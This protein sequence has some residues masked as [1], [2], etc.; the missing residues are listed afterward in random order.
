MRTIYVFLILSLSIFSIVSSSTPH[1]SITPLPKLLTTLYKTPHD[2]SVTLSRVTETGLESE[3]VL[4]ELLKEHGENV[5][6]KGKT[7]SL[8]KRISDEFKDRLVQVSLNGREEGR[9]LGNDN[10]DTDHDTYTFIT[11]NNPPYSSQILLVTAAVSALFS[12]LELRSHKLLHPTVPISPLSVFVEP[13]VIL[14]IL[15]M[16]AAVGV[17][18]GMSAESS[19]SSLSKLNPSTATLVR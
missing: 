11:L 16:N 1:A 6:P 10:N 15:F 2:N 18:M 8:I 7:R 14:L 3:N 9:G 12:F 13:L 17:K 19:L 5:L 4:I